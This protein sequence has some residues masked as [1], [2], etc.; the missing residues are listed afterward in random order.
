VLPPRR[1]QIDAIGFH[2]EPAQQPELHF[3]SIVS[4]SPAE[5]RVSLA[6]AA[7]DTLAQFIDRREGCAGS[8]ALAH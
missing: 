6:L 1:S 2:L 3:V 7:P 5:P 8:R 4:R